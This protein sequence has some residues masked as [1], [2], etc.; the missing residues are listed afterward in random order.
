VTLE[1]T[2]TGELDIF[3][4]QTFCMSWTRGASIQQVMFSK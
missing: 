4:C 1:G 3:I 2:A